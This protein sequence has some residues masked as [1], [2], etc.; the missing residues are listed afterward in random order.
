M[1]FLIYGFDLLSARQILRVLFV[2]HLRAANSVLNYVAVA[3]RTS[4]RAKIGGEKESRDLEHEI[5][6]L[7]GRTRRSAA[8]PNDR[9]GIARR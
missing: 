6:R 3:K 5:R 9:N 8:E 4:K 2:K 7:R 1:L